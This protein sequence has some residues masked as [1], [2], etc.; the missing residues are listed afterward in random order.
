ME[1]PPPPPPGPPVGGDNQPPGSDGYSRM[2]TAAAREASAN[3]PE[4]APAY[5]A[6]PDAGASGRRSLSPVYGP[7]GGFLGEL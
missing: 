6:F 5:V 7:A 1:P 3:E 2:V 4:A